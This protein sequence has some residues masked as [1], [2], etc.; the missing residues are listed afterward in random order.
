MRNAIIALTRGYPQNKS[1]YDTLIKRNESIYNHINKHRNVPA[2]MI[3]FHEGNISSD[4]QSYI[5]S[6][7]PDEIKFVDISK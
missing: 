1:L 3:L 6:H 4:D 7:Y 2:D 5:N